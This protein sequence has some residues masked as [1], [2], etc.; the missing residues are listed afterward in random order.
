[1]CSA[2]F[3]FPQAVVK[4]LTSDLLPVMEPG[5]YPVQVEFE[6]EVTGALGSSGA[7]VPIKT[8]HD[9]I[10]EAIQACPHL[11]DEVLDLAR[12]FTEAVRSR[13]RIHRG[14]KFSPDLE[15]KNC[16]LTFENGFSVKVEPQEMAVAY[17]IR[18]QHRVDFDLD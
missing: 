13:L 5:Y 11:H 1:K 6:V 3:H 17:P 10:L 18:F 4:Q 2:L 14:G 7:L 8:L 15:L 12:S 9:L 16:T